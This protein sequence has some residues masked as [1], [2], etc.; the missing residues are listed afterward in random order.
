MLVLHV[1]GML[2]RMTH[3]RETCCIFKT[4]HFSHTYGYLYSFIEYYLFF[5]VFCF[6]VSM[7]PFIHEYELCVPFVKINACSVLF[8]S[9]LFSS[10]ALFR[11]KDFL[12][13]NN[14]VLVDN[15]L[16]FELY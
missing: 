12:F 10:F 11:K 6:V 5:V 16:N 9:L 15:V 4:Y 1:K 3:V 2:N 14:N 13:R 8:C 7:Q